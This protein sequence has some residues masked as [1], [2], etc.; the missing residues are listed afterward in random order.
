MNFGFGVKSAAACWSAS[1][2]MLPLLDWLMEA[3][4][5]QRS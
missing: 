4:C 2:V 5:Q 3:V 1:E